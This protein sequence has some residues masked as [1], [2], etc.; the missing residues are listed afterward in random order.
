MKLIVEVELLVLELVLDEVLLDVEDD[1]LELVLEEVLEDVLLLVLDEVE[2]LAIS[3][4]YIIY[5]KKINNPNRIVYLLIS[6]S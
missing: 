5:K 1:I 2:L 6:I 3:Q 4:I